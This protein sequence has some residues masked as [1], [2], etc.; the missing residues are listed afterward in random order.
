MTLYTEVRL[1]YALDVS[2]LTKR[3]GAVVA[4]KELDIKIQ[5]GS[6]V[7]IIGTN[8]AGKTTFIN[9][10]T[11][12]TKPDAGRVRFAGQDIT[13]FG[14]RAITRMGLGRS[15][16]IPQL[17]AG[18][19]VEENLV[20]AAAIARMRLGNMFSLGQDPALVE[21]CQGI[22]RAFGLTPFRGLLVEE[23]AG[24]TR[25][26]VDIAMALVT[27]PKMLL[28]DE[29]TSGVSSQEKAHLMDQVLFVAKQRELTT[30]LVEHDMEVVRAYSDRVL[31]FF[32]GE[33]IADG[34]PPVV[35]DDA[36]VRELI[37]GS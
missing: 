8:G 12:Y 37:I 30:V 9:M 26:L 32:A 34:T 4:A 20:T 23:L 25:K 17:F 36:R 14:P 10:V 19:S 28:L 5:R 1:T 35:L 18:Y 16:Q 11:G 13:G 29:P 21:P 6:V 24:G 7:S 31:A 33:V 15:F 27:E 3:F 22:L 2:G